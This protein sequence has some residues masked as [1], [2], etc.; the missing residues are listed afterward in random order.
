MTLK[1]RANK[2]AD[3]FQN[4][5]AKVIAFWGVITGGVALIPSVIGVLVWVYYFAIDIYN[6]SNYVKEFRAATEY[7]YF[8]D[9]QEAKGLHE[10]METVT[11]YGVQ[12]EKTSSGDLWLFTT[13]EVNGV[14]RPIIY[15]VNIKKKGQ[16]IKVN[17]KT[18]TAHIYIQN[19]A[20]EHQ[21]IP[22]NQ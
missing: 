10:G 1:E 11:K 16:K 15:S 8:L 4:K 17:G 14:E 18:V 21:W 7:S 13:V 12:L 20:N 19:M 3:K 9:M 22:D 6:I 2:F 5:T